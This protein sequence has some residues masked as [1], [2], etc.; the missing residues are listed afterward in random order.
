VRDELVR[1]CGE[2]AQLRRELEI[3]ERAGPH[4][5]GATLDGR[6]LGADEHDGHGVL[7]LRKHARH[8]G[9]A[10][11]PEVGVGDDDVRARALER[12][13]RPGTARDADDGEAR[14]FK[15]GG[16]TT[17]AGVVG[18]EQKAA[19]VARWLAAAV[20]EACCGGHQEELLRN[21]SQSVRSNGG[22]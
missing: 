12:D 15:P 6:R 8:L 2:Q 5:L 7:R 22:R 11:A 4:R 16:V 20:A 10:Y 1:A 17:H 18:D 14:L 3:V 21:S 13:E 9:G 19:P